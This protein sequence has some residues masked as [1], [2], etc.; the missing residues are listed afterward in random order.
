M[1][2]VKSSYV[3]GKM[4]PLLELIC[5]VYPVI[6]SL[7]VMWTGFRHVHT[8]LKIYQNFLYSYEK[9]NK[10]QQC[11]KIYFIFIW[12]ST[13][14]GRHTAHHQEPK[15]ALEASGFAW[16]RGRLDSCPA[17]THATTFR[18]IM[19]SQRL[20]VQFW[21]LIM[22]GVLPETCRASY[23]YEINFDTLLHL[24]GFLYALYY[25]AWIH[26]HQISILNL[27]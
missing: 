16:Y 1:L 6:L 25:D 22:G 24:V 18:D 20:L 23:K 12:S 17:T 2:S 3:A 9:S 19:Q 4:C 5:C 21:L 14:F 7:A 8:A 11:I 15:T 13:C 10:M 27:K 26:Q